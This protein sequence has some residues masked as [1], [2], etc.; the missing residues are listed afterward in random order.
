[1]LN[2]KSILSLTVT[3]ALFSLSACVTTPNTPEVAAKPAPI[4]TP[5]T[6]ISGAASLRVTINNIK[7]PEGNISAA[8]FDEAGYK[9]GPQ[10]RGMNADVS[11]DSVV[12]DFAD[13]PAG[14]YG[15]KLFHDVNGNGNMDTNPFGIPLEPYAFSNSAAGMMGPAK[16]DAAKFTVQAGDNTHTITFR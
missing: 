15:I 16:W 13:L 10:I 3:G 14:E 7:T 2:L 11:G 12:L 1:M 9:G 4:S 6:E 5:S 8:L